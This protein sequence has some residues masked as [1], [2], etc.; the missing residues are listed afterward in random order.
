MLHAKSKSHMADPLSVMPRILTKLHSLWVTATYPFADC[1]P[2]VSI[3]YSA[4]LHRPAAQRIKLGREVCIGKDVWLNVA[5]NLD[6]QNDPTIVIDDNCAIARG[7]MISAKNSIHFEPDVLFG[8]SALIMDHSHAYEDVTQSIRNQGVTEGGRIRIGQGCWIGHG[9]VIVCV[10]GEL[11]LGRNC[12]VGAN[13]LVTRSFPAYSVISGNP[14][15]VVKQFD[16]I[17][18]VWV[19]GSARTADVA[20]VKRS[21]D[22]ATVSQ[23]V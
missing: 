7:S 9:A 12:V 13:S 21:E 10:Q 5:G 16:P 19:L 14:A 4:E 1:G 6:S 8:P 17:K 3:H 23:L 18:K 15:R 11:T 22:T 2:H 20:A